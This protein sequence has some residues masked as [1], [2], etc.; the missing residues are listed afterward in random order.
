MFRLWIKP[1]IVAYNYLLNGYCVIGEMTA[2]RK[3]FD[4]MHFVGIEPGLKS[5]IIY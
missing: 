5:I 1:E 4:N 3:L 2:V